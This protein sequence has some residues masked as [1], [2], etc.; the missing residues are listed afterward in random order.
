MPDGSHPLAYRE[1]SIASHLRGIAN[2]NATRRVLELLRLDV[3]LL[4]QAGKLEEAL[5]SCHAM[6]NVGRS[7]GDEPTFLAL[8]ARLACRARAIE[9]LERVLA[10]GEAP[11]AVFSALQR[12]L[13]Q[14]AQS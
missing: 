3:L 13:E 7:S 11:E 2:L 5:R 9:L 4:V 6:I 14:E 1:D 10:H 12:H 8:L